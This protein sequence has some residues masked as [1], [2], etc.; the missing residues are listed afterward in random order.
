MS[1]TLSAFKDY[2]IIE[3]KTH[4]INDHEFRTTTLN[5]KIEQI[6][7][8]T[9]IHYTL[10]NKNIYGFMMTSLGTEPKYTEEISTILNSLKITKKTAEKTPDSDKNMTETPQATQSSDQISTQ[11]TTNK[12]STYNSADVEDNTSTSKNSSSNVSSG[13][14]EESTNNSAPSY[15]EEEGDEIVYIGASGN[16]YHR[17]NCRTLKNGGKAVKLSCVKN[18]QPCKVCNP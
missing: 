10:R 3:K 13:T 18:R 15:S 7:Y 4:Q 12:T 1:G 9:E 6:D 5:H 16:K 14:K 11:D 2:T 17:E 8:Y